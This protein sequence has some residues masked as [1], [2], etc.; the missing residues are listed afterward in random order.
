MQ[1]VRGALES[2]FTTTTAV[3]GKSAHTYVERVIV[4][5]SKQHTVA[6]RHLNR[7][8]V[9][10]ASKYLGSMQNNLFTSYIELSS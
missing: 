6:R 4:A 7:A 1:S 3:T 10:L 8:K 5:E 2:E 9:E